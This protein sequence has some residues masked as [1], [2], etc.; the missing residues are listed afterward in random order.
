ME[1]S[2][3]VDAKSSIQECE[4]R[5]RS[6]SLAGV[7]GGGMANG[8]GVGREEELVHIRVTTLEGVEILVSASER[9]YSFELAGGTGE[10]VGLL[11][12]HVLLSPLTDSTTQTVTSAASMLFIQQHEIVCPAHEFS[13]P[14]ESATS[15][16]S[17]FLT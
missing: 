10:E 12:G 8:D 1:G 5:V 14:F 3:L 4:K 17:S 6:V 7:V 11:L 15:N 13:I 16:L 2:V 9:G